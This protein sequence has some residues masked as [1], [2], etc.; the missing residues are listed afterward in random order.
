MQ[1]IPASPAQ[2]QGDAAG[3][4]RRIKTVLLVSMVFSCLESREQ[5]MHVAI[6]MGSKAPGKPA[7]P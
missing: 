2:F 5:A 4:W 3:V 1:Q 7:L 6:S